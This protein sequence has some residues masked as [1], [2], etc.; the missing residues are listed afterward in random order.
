MSALRSG[1]VATRKAIRA[2]GCV[3]ALRLL[4]AWILASPLSRAL[5]S[6]GATSHPRGDAILF[7]P[8][9]L[10]LLD[11]IRGSLPVLA[12][13]L[14]GSLIIGGVL[15]W[16]TLIPVGGL[17]C[18]LAEP[19]RTGPAEWTRRGIELL[20]RL[21]V[22]FGARLFFQGLIAVIAALGIGALGRR[23]DLVWDERRADLAQ[24]GL[25]LL[26]VCIVLGLGVIEDLA[27]VEVAGGARVLAAL[28]AALRS[29]RQ[30]ALVILALATFL[31]VAGLCLALGGGALLGAIDVGRTGAA[32]VT[33]ATLVHQAVI[34]GL[35]AL[36]SVWLGALM[37]LRTWAK[38][39][40][41]SAPG[42]ED[43]PIHREVAASGAIPADVES[44]DPT[45]QPGH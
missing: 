27:R 23:L 21:S 41:P 13:Q 45:P 15:A 39:A 37:H 12:S 35:I 17:L 44:H 4:V 33:A 25:A 5:T 32:R 36:R 29:L 11:A 6:Q 22:L 30:H 24:L 3:W 28:R 18:A 8:G 1:F 20:P 34:F 10:E 2:V 43:L 38:T 26:S 40:P 7:E 19:H 16:L 31:L 14:R 42:A 9:G